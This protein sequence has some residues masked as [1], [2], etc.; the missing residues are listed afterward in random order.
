MINVEQNALQSIIDMVI[1]LIEIRDKSRPCIF[2]ISNQELNSE[3]SIKKFCMLI[4]K[5]MKNT[6]GLAVIIEKISSL[7]SLSDIAS[8]LHA[9]ARSVTLTRI[10]G[11]QISN[12]INPMSVQNLIN[13]LPA[14]CIIFVTAKFWLSGGKSLN[15]PKGIPEFNEE[16]HTIEYGY[17]AKCAASANNIDNFIKKTVLNPNYSQNIQDI[18]TTMELTEAFLLSLCNRISP[19]FIEKITQMLEKQQLDSAKFP[20]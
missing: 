20:L 15:I 13:S 17:Q 7:S 3:S 4:A 2:S 19:I 1:T 16:N 9:E 5:K 12:T 11:L 10:V 14:N 18:G 6:A 8:Q